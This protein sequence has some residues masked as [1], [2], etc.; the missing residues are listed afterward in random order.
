MNQTLRDAFARQLDDAGRLDVDI[1]ALIDQGETR[2]RHRRLAVVVGAA[3]AVVL[4]LA[5]IAG[6]TGSHLVGRGDGPV[7]HPPTPVPTPSPTRPIVY[8][9]TQFDPGSG[10]DNRSGDSIHVGNRLVNTGSSFIHMDVTDD[11]A[12]YATGGYT[13][14]GR[15]WFTDGGTPVQIG[16]H[17]CAAPHGAANTVVTG[18]SGSL[19]AW[20]DCTRTQDPA[21]VVYDTGPGHEVV[22]EQVSQCG[23]RYATC[24]ADAIIGDHVYFTWTHYPHGGHVVVTPLEFDMAT[25]RISKVK[26]AKGAGD[27]LFPDTY[28]GEPQAYLDDIRSNPRGLVIG[29]SWETGTRTPFGLGFSVVGKRLVPD[30]NL[31]AEP[32]TSA[33]D[34]AI[35]RPVHLHLP[36]GYHG[37][38][39]FGI[40]AWLDD[41]TVALIGPT[42]W[43]GETFG[44]QLEPGYGDILTCH[45][46]DGHCDLAAP[47]HGPVRLA[48]GSAVPG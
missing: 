14:E 3:A 9:D 23:A 42:G 13:D 45:L 34:T 7:D 12:V 30:S 38:V 29:D 33:F 17:A 48:A 16:S 32:R 47:G 41:D 27:A 2:L 10:L 31:P 26:L 28:D 18:N 5:T 8:S 1:E 19:A 44:G 25:G 43:G 39:D 22:R 11:G 21:L 20:F 40:F 4:V 15:V 46:S 37:A 6:V 24:Y 36:A 35:H